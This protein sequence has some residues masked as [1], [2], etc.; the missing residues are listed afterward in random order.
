MTPGVPEKLA[1]DLWSTAITFEAGHKIALHVRLSNS[2]RFE[3]NPND[4]S[5]PGVVAE[6]GQKHDALWRRQAFRF[7]IASD[8]LGAVREQEP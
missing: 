8:L 1:N 3:V 7:G 6:N 2:P 5:A 4:S